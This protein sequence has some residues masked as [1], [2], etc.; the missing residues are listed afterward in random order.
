MEIASSSPKKWLVE[1][2]T[3]SSSSKH[4]T[5]SAM[6]QVAVVSMAKNQS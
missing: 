5:G 1:M 3:V 2:E 4:M 6:A